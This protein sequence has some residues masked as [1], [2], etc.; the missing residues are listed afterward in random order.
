MLAALGKAFIEHRYQLW[1]R[2]ASATPQWIGDN[3]EG[4]VATLER[5]YRLIGEDIEEPGADKFLQRMSWLQV[6]IADLEAGRARLD[7]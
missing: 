1:P 6:L 2:G 4:I 3:V 7:A 5:L